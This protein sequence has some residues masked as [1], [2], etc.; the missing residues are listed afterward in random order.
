MNLV[1]S[2]PL[3][4]IKK[5]NRN[6]IGI[7]YYDIYMVDKKIFTNLEHVMATTICAALNNAYRTGILDGISQ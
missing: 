7:R 5:A 1:D 3:Y 4:S 6:V 2:E